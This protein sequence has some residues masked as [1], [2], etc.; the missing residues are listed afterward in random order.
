MFEGWTEQEKKRLG[1][2]NILK[3]C[4]PDQTYQG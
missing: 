2:E 3:K 4:F 1:L